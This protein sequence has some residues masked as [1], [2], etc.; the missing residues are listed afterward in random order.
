[1]YAVEEKVGCEEPS[2][3]REPF[4]DV[5]EKTMHPILD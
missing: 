4:V 5:K 3:I 2:V 1:M